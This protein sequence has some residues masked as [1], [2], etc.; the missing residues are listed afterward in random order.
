MDAF[1]HGEKF[2]RDGKYS[3]AEPWF[4][5]ALNITPTD[6]NCRSWLADSLMRQNKF[7]EALPLYEFLTKTFTLNA[8][9]A[10]EFATCLKGLGRLKD[11]LIEYQRAVDLEP[12]NS[13]YQ[14]YV[15]LG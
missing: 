14:S 15:S 4:R 8:E 1:S 11:A 12:K 7:T 10:N 5:K 13:L 2:F 3:E 9:Y 6:Q